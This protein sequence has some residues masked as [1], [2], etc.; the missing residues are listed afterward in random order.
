MR[1]SDWSSDVCSSDLVVAQESDI[2]EL[3]EPFSI[4]DH[5]RILRPVAKGEERREGRFDRRHIGGDLLVAE[6]LPR[7]VLARGVANLGRAAAHQHDGLRAQ[8]R[9]VGKEWG[10]TCRS[11][12]WPDN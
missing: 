7:I 4:I 1:I 9:R 5:H 8:E 6:Q 11:R 2:F 10:S 3:V 12:W